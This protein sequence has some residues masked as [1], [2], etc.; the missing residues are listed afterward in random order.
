MNAPLNKCPLCGGLLLAYYVKRYG[1]RVIAIPSDG[2]LQVD[3][4]SMIGDAV[5]VL[6][7][8][9]CDDCC[10]S[11]RSVAAVLAVKKG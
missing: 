3:R 1:H 4:G 8:I 2:Y 11:W 10:G 5:D 7:E 6:D 9:V